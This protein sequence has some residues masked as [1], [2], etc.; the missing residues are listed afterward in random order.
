LPFSGKEQSQKENKPTTCSNFCTKLANGLKRWP[1][2]GNPSHAKDFGIKERKH[3][4]LA[5]YSDSFCA[6][7]ALMAV[8]R[9]KLIAIPLYA[10]KVRH[11][12]KTVLNE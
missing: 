6:Y 9:A 10:K 1:P 8:C 7:S 2:Q 3:N 5:I 11:T 4:T 12:E